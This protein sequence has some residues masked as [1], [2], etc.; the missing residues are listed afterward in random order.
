M[1]CSPFW[2]FCDGPFGNSRFSAPLALLLLLTVCP[3]L[4][5]VKGSCTSL[6]IY[7]G[8]GRLCLISVF[9]LAY[10]FTA[11]LI[12]VDL[13][14]LFLAHSSADGRITSCAISLY[15][16]A[17]LY[18]LKDFFTSLSSPEWKVR[19]AAFPPDLRADG[20]FSRKAYSTSNSLFTSIRRAWKVLAQDFFTASFLSF[21][22]RKESASS[23]ASRSCVVV[24]ILPPR[25][26]RLN[27]VWEISSA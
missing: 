12:F 7:E 26:S 20:S 6:H 21:S 3:S 5:I 9:F 27:T 1:L 16:P 24:S 25:F 13:A 17:L 15:R 10:A 14:R 11:H 4:L 8:T 18:S 22:G 19:I 23:T 2:L